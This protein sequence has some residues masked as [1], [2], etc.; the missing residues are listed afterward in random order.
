MRGK[1]R[2]CIGLMALSL[3]G[4][5]ARAGDPTGVNQA[6]SGLIASW[7]EAAFS[8]DVSGTSD[9][10]VSLDRPIDVEYE[11][12]VPGYLTYVRISS[13]GDMTVARSGAA[14]ATGV[15]HLLAQA[16]LGDEQLLLLFSN[17]P[18]DA[19]FP[20]GETTR[21]AGSD[22]QSASDLVQRVVH[23]EANGIRIAARRYHYEVSAPVGGTEY[24][25]RGITYQVLGSGAPAAPEVGSS[26]C[27]LAARAKHDATGATIPAHVEF[28]FN[29][30]QLTR[31]GQLDLDEFGAALNGPLKG[32]GVVLQGNT[33]AM[34]S[35]DYNVTLSRRRAEAARR[36]LEDSFAIG[37]D[38]LDTVA[39]GKNNPI[40]PND[41]DADRAC[42]RRVDFVISKPTATAGLR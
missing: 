38:R 20:N 1:L 16:P 17:A 15:V 28:E 37:H 8:I 23:L 40:A 7:P 30:D 10:Q 3:P 31:Q 24:T 14:L 27:P 29:S 35:D 21:V 25:T 42:N 4:L 13:H 41:N 11:A 2:T 22:G 5:W 6:F 34:G 36:Y 19:L 26:R 18:L 12:G 9:G 39:M 32:S 33:D